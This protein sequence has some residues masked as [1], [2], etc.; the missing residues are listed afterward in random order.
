[1]AKPKQNDEKND[2]PTEPPTLGEQWR[3]E[4]RKA[5]AARAAYEAQEHIANDLGS[6]VAK[7]LIDEKGGAPIVLDGVTFQPK[8]TATRKNSDGTPKPS[9]FPYQLVRKG[10]KE[11]VEV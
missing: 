11:A 5:D 6:Q 9:E 1:M 8:K 10:N 3:I 4:Q 2:Q 7:K